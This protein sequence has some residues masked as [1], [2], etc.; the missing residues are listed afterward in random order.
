VESVDIV[1]KGD[2]RLPGQLVNMSADDGDAFAEVAAAQALALQ[3]LPTLEIDAAQGG[4][5]ALAGPLVQV[6]VMNQQP[7]TEG[8]GAVGEGSHDLIMIDGHVGAYRQGGHEQH[9]S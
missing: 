1:D 4:T 2:V 8:T 7:L 3:H 9:G 5:S 6:A